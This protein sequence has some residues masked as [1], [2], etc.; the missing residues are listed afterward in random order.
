MTGLGIYMHK[1]TF[2]DPLSEI[3]RRKLLHVLTG[4]GTSNNFNQFTGNGSLTLSVVQNLESS[5][6]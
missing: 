1:F 2:I 6:G 4:G 3:S 5:I